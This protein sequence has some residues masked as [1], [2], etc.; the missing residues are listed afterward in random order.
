MSK[1]TK[2]LTDPV[3]F[4]ADAGVGGAKPAE[5]VAA[6]KPVVPRPQAVVIARELADA[7]PMLDVSAQYQSGFQL[8]LLASARSKLAAYLVERA[9]SRRENI[10]IRKKDESVKLPRARVFEVEE[11]LMGGTSVHVDFQP[12]GQRA[13][14]R[15][16]IQFWDTQA[17]EQVFGPRS[18]PWARR[19]SLHTVEQQGLFRPGTLVHVRDV[20]PHAI[21]H[22]VTFPVD[23]VYTWV[24]HEDPDWRGMFQAATGKHADEHEQDDARGLERFVNREELKYSLRSLAAHAPWVRRVF[25][26]SNCKPPAWLNLEHPRLQWVDHSEILPADA[27]PTFNSHAIES[28]LHHVPGIAN[29]FLYFNDDFFL[30]RKTIPDDFFQSNGVSKSVLES[31]GA[32][33]GEVVATDPDYLNAARNGKRLMEQAFGRSAV[34]LHR[35][36]PYALRADVLAEIEARFPTEL[37]RTTRSS[38]R[39]SDDIS[40]V[41][42]FYHHYA[43]LTDRS[44]YASSDSVL[45]KP[46]HVGYQRALRQLLRSADKKPI[47]V[48]LNDGAGSVQVEGWSACVKS[49][50]AAAFPKPSQFERKP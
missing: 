32:V 36:T 44:T 19:L 24:D 18:N 49:F 28:R 11:I 45:V 12:V 23:V 30:M 33:N 41:S 29:Q 4:F 27:L 35:H 8:A 3:A 1:V 7:L 48:C 2:F 40:L 5:P 16:T 26:V 39:S 10:I 14:A 6:P 13:T 38:F 46:Q 25:I 20:N 22:E 37:G 17:G 9:T 31:Y 47:S 34:A 21:T 50:L 43:Y 15:V 42:F